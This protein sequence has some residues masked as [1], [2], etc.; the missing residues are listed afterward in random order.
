VDAEVGK[1]GRRMG[2]YSEEDASSS[3]VLVFERELACTASGCACVQIPGKY[4]G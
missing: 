3:G 2:T 1:G 4:G